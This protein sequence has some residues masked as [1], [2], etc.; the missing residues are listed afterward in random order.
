MTRRRGASGTS[1]NNEGEAEEG[2]PKSEL[3]KHARVFHYEAQVGGQ[4]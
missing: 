4:Q 2:K 1:G 3:P